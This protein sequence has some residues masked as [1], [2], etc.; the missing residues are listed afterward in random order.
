MLTPLYRLMEAIPSTR[1]G[2]RRLGLVSSEQMIAA[3]VQA[4]ERP[5][6][7]VRVV[8]VPQIRESAI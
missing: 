6:A 7:G 5:A 2:A 1:D 3:L 4:V 8:E